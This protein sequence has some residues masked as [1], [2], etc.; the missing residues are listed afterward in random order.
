MSVFTGIRK[1][2]CVSY[3]KINDEVI[4]NKT[5]LTYFCLIKK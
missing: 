2:I 4:Y 5:F 1:K 3:N